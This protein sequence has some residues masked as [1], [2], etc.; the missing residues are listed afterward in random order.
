MP[1]VTLS[2]MGVGPY[3]FVDISVHSWCRKGSKDSVEVSLNLSQQGPSAMKII[4]VLNGVK[5]TL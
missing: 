5:H 1:Q 3:I 2:N 4:L